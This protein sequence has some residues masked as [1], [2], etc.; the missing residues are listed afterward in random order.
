MTNQNDSFID[1]V[2]ADL[3][4]DR[5]F[6]L[7]RRFGWIAVLAI[8]AIVGGSAWYE[9]S[10]VENNRQAQA[11]GDAVLAAENAEDP[12]A[13]LAAVDPG[14]ATG[15]QLVA[16]L[17]TAGALGD[18]D[19][20]AQAADE[21]T[22]LAEATGESDPLMRDLALLKAVIAAGPGMDAARRD[23]ALTELS[24]PGAPFELLA[25]E[26]KAVA[27]MGAGRDEDAIMLIRQIQ[28][29]DGL[30]EGLRLRLAEMMIT[31]GA[32]PEP[33]ASAVVAPAALD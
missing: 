7:M 3:R 11:F 15:R 4:R 9:Y 26:Q 31:L 27:L 17:L 8:L 29:K 25:L 6:R 18:A 33:E 14:T 24:R 22:A 13:A 19:K 23:A 5:A 10:R 28:Q 32:E 1:E 21:L 20:G 30:T 12:A 16:G 2:T